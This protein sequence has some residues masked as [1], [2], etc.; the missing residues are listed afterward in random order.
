[1]NVEYLLATHT[2]RYD[3][4]S[5]AWV[6]MR[7][8]SLSVAIAIVVMVVSLA[9]IQGFRHEIH[10]DLKGFASD[11]VVVD[12]ATLGRPEGIPIRANEAF[13]DQIGAIDE[14]E[15]IAAYASIGGMVKMAIMFADCNS[16][17]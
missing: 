10:A 13:A 12:M 3:K 4:G 6:M 1:M 9:V 16:R 15:H 7:I 2:A 5:R 8:T 11:I 14:V 17:V